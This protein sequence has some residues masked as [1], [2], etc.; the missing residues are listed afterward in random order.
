MKNPKI[1]PI[2]TIDTTI[3]AEVA[4]KVKVV[5]ETNPDEDLICGKILASIR[6]VKKAG[7]QISS[8]EIENGVQHTLSIGDATVNLTRTQAA[9]KKVGTYVI[10]V[11]APNGQE[12][13][14]FSNKWFGK[15]WGALHAELH[16]KE[17]KTLS[18][19]SAAA[20]LKAFGL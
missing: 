13:S 11:V 2:A 19:S 16:V 15:I 18:P 3:T 7:S 5:K 12:E 10:T 17:D 8:T 14:N 1:A 20:C 6:E 4:P 9:D